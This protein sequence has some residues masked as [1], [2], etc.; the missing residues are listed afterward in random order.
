MENQIPKLRV[1]GPGEVPFRLKNHCVIERCDHEKVHST[2]FVIFRFG[3]TFWQCEIESSAKGNHPPLRAVQS[4]RV[5][6]GPIFS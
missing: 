1:V 4:Y 5:D 3:R 2:V 6:I